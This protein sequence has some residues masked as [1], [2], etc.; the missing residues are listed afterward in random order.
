[1]VARL[2]L[3]LLLT[4]SPAP[5]F[6]Q[7]TKLFDSMLA[8]LRTLDSWGVET[9]A[10]SGAWRSERRA[11]I[12]FQ[13]PNR[14]HISVIAGDRGCDVWGDGRAIRAL[15][16]D[17]SGLRSLER[18]SPAGREALPAAVRLLDD[19]LPAAGLDGVDPGFGPLAGLLAGISP[20]ERGLRSPAVLSRPRQGL[21]MARFVPGKGPPAAAELSMEIDEH[22]HLPHRIRYTTAAPGYTGVE[23]EFLRWQ[24]PLQR[25]IAPA[26]PA[27]NARAVNP[28]VHK[29]PAA[30]AL[31]GGVLVIAATLWALSRRI[32]VRLVLSL[33]SLALG[34]LAGEPGAIVRKF[35]STL[36]D[37]RYVIPI[38][39]AMG[40]AYVLRHTLCDQHLVQLLTRPLRRIVPLLIPG[41]VLVGYFVNIPI[42]SQTSTAVAIGP[43]LIPLL[44][45]GGLTP[46]TAGAA[47]LLGASVGGEL[48]N[49][50]APEYRTVLEKSAELGRWSADW[51]LL[52]LPR[53]STMLVHRTAALNLLQLAV[54]L[55][56]FWWLSLKAER[57]HGAERR[58]AARQH[59]QP[60]GAPHFHVNLYKAFVPLAPL[61]ILFLVGGD[62]AKPTQIITL[63][64]E[65]LVDARSK[66]DQISP[67]ATFDA[68][69]IGAAML[70]GVALA[71]LGDLKRASGVMRAFFDGAGFA[72]AEVIAIIVGAS[73]FGE[74]I[75]L[76]GLAEVVGQVV[77]QIPALLIPLAASIPLLMGWVS[78]SGMASTQGLYEFFARPA[79]SIGVDPVLVGSVV[80]LGSA[81]GRTM[82]PVAAVTLMSARLTETAA[83][84][85]LRRVT[86]PLILG[87]AAMT[88]AAML[89][90]R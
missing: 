62:A 33:A 63:P 71:A 41:A 68:R 64:Q 19:E 70:I 28:A 55:A 44:L 50:G 40:F 61:A 56:A 38:C 32:D 15:Y 60:A 57:A 42:I 78:G 47:L 21:I 82:S 76:L 22:S 9:R 45:A 37:E 25:E 26:P 43:V 13:S 89:M 81:A 90:S 7:E 14:L 18:E 8:R 77:Q 24:T 20:L 1:M 6:S 65:W 86:L 49:P 48:W 11:R 17:G 72:V 79:W 16:R 58:A 3:L 30:P 54:S 2:L 84:D 59:D 67:A 46:V 75:R 52:P 87:A 39:S 10:S 29:D 83:P 35:F 74:G 27:G 88:A 69:L 85:L 80:S 66:L 5:A 51:S 12:E 31:F 4:L 53:D 23:I 36:A 34:L 73:C